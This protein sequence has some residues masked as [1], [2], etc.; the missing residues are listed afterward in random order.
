MSSEVKILDFFKSGLF[1]QSI[2]YYLSLPKSEQIQPGILN[3]VAASYF[4][5][6]EYNNANTCLEQA[7]P[8]LSDNPSFLSLYASNTRL[9]GDLKK[10]N[11]LFLKALKIDPTSLLIRNNY[12]NL[13]IDMGQFD[14]ASEILSSILKVDPEYQDA[15]SNYNRLKYKKVA[16]QKTINSVEDDFAN[17]SSL[18]GFSLAD[19]LLLAFAD[20]EVNYA[21]KRYKLQ[22]DKPVQTV[23]SELPSSKSDQS[24]VEQLDV[25]R[26]SLASGEFQFC[27]KLCS[28]LLINLSLNSEIYDC[29][30]DAYLNLRRFRE[31]EICRLMPLV[32]AEVHPK[33]ISILLALLV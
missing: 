14:S 21:R 26:Q 2:S 33:G 13:L 8:H 11:E 1:N 15:L 32:L 17:N 16:S 3:I 18:S 22:N 30:S 28:N 5:I 9:L 24:S 6:G 27:L 12:A 25:A 4:R 23:L 10:S 7:E 20:K 31:S 29:A 19:P